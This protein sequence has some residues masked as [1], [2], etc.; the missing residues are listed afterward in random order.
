MHSV[1]GTPASVACA[2]AGYIGVEKRPEGEGREVIWQIAAPSSSYTHL[3]K[4][5][6]LYKAERKIE[7]SQGAG[8]IQ[9][10]VSVQDD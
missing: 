6:A 7:N 3:S 1:A 8:T 4:R 9:S 2:D 5:S 10:R